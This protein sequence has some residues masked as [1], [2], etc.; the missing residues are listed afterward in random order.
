M[1]RDSLPGSR[2]FSAKWRLFGAHYLRSL[3]GATRR[4][5]PPNLASATEVDEGR[6]FSMLRG[7]LFDGHAATIR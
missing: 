6:R 1:A 4:E 3:I 5:S 2:G 7:R